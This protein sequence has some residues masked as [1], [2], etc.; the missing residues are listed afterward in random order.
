MTKSIKLLVCLLLLSSLFSAEAQTINVASCSQTDVQKAFNSITNSTRTVNIPVG[1]CHWTSKVSLN[2]PSGDPNL[3]VIGAG[4]CTGTPAS[5]CNDATTIIDDDS[6]DSDVLLV[7]RISSTFS[8][9]FRFSGISIKGGTGSLKQNGTV[10]VGG[11]SHNVRLDHIHMDL[12]TYTNPV[13]RYYIR[14]DSVTGVVDHSVFEGNSA[15][16]GALD[17]WNSFYNGST[18]QTGDHAWAAPTGFGTGDFMFVEDSTFNNRGVAGNEHSGSMTDCRAGKFVIRHNILNRMGIMDHPTGG[19]GRG[20]GCRA[21][22]MYLNNLTGTD[23]AYDNNLVVAWITSGTALVWGNSASETGF[24]KF[25][26]LHSERKYKQY[27]SGW[28]YCGTSFGP[29]NFD[30][31]LDVPTGWGCLDQPGQGQSDLLTND[32]PN[33]ANKATG[34]RQ[35]SACVWPRQKLEPVYEWMDSWGCSSCGGTGVGFVTFNEAYSPT[36]LHNNR[37]YYVWC[38]PSSRSGCTSFNGTVGVGSGLLSARPSACTAGPGGNTPG[39]GYWATDQNTLYVCS[40]TNTWTAYYTPYTYPHP[41]TQ[42]SDHTRAAPT[43][44]RPVVH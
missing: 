17:F 37:D 28:G 13:S 31:N 42:G 1:T 9:K 14:L 40:R 4:T 5:S 7:L 32:F 33:V 35:T 8:A 39:V 23:A 34:C 41:L 26:S 43:A 3:S 30:Q 29:S 18:D 20:R 12:T 6:T 36:V 2:V 27:R 16:Q 11:N 44:R 24:A 38:D 21:R 19:N 22:E 25:L 10:A 15:G